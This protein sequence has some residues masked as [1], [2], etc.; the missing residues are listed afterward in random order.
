MGAGEV[1][2][3][4]AQTLSEQGENV[5]VIELDPVKQARIEEELDVQVVPGNGAH[6]P[7]LEAAGVRFDGE[8]ETIEG[9]VSIAT[10]F[11]PD[12]NALMLAEDLSES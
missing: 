7:V 4:L 8:T 6:P 3:H 5:A 10:F 1:G 2:Y 11:D 12:G 9:M